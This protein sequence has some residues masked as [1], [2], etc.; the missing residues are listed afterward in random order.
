MD[1]SPVNSFRFL[2]NTYFNADLELLPNR[3]YF[4]TSARY[5]QF[6]DVTGQT[7]EACN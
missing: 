6:M 3:Q 2:F 1:L 7:E 4:S 5:Y